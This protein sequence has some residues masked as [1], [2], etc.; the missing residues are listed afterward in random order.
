M[1]DID[2]A[3]PE[4]QVR[5]NIGDVNREWVSDSTI[6]S[7]LTAYNNN[8]NNT[9]IALFEMLCTYFATLADREVVGEVQ[10][11]YTKLYERYKERL[12]D[13]KDTGGA[14]PSTKAFMPYI[15]GGTSKSKKKEIYAN[16]DA[17]SMYDLADWHNAH[18]G[19]RSLYEM[20]TQDIDYALYQSY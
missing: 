10:V 19:N 5:L 13:F 11:Y 6:I 14:L 1:L 15:I 18:L 2:F 4:D 8:V 12:K 17:A 7:A 3:L 9:S 20:L 16:E